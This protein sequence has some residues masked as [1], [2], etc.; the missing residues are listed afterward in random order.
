MRE[1]FVCNRPHDLMSHRAVSKSR[2]AKRDDSK[3]K[4]NSSTIQIHRYGAPIK[5]LAT[6][7]AN[8]IARQGRSGFALNRGCSYLLRIKTLPAREARTQAWFVALGA[9][10]TVVPGLTRP[11]FTR[12][13]FP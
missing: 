4:Q 7:R 5:T 11:R 9:S 8:D 1:S 12:R 13:S 6:H 2:S 3:R 10:V